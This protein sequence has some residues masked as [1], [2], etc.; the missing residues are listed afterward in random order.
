MRIGAAGIWGVLGFSALLGKAIYQLTPLAIAALRMPLDAIQW[1]ALAAW[2]VVAAWSEG[3]RAFQLQL[4]PRLAARAQYLT[5]HP[6][7]LFVVLAPFYCM[8]LIH[9]TRKRLITSW[10]VLLGVVGLV[11]A[12]R[13]LDQPWRGI[14]DAGVVIGLSWGLVAI[15]YYFVRGL[16]APIDA[17][18]DVP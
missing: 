15:G 17:S 2:V 13:L 10:S 12:V 3:Y 6:K 4:A 7:P 18:P 14:V 11:I 9:A 8:G 16:R 1:A 5:A